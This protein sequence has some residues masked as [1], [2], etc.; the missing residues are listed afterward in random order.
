MELASR[1]T[2]ERAKCPLCEPATV[3]EWGECSCRGCVAVKWWHV[4]E[5]LL[6]AR[7]CFTFAFIEAVRRAAL[8]AELATTANPLHLEA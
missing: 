1:R 2:A 3:S 4:P 6:P 8:R 7:R 5:L